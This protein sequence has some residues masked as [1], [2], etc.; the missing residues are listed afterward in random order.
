MGYQRQR[1]IHLCCL[2][3]SIRWRHLMRQEVKLTLDSDMPWCLPTLKC[4]LRRQHFSVFGCSQSVVCSLFPCPV[5]YVYWCY[6]CLLPALCYSWVRSLKTVICDYSYVYAFL[7]PH[8]SNRDNYKC[9]YFI[10]LF[11]MSVLFLK[12]FKSKIYPK[13]WFCVLSRLQTSLF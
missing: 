3:K 11:E 4:V 13:T 1:R 6:L 5:L 8:S 7:A 12:T 9:F 2:Q 10:L